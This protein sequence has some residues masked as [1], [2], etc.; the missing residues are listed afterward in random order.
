MGNVQDSES[1]S[2]QNGNSRPP[3]RPPK[4]APLPPT[5]SVY[6][7]IANN[8]DHD[9]EILNPDFNNRPSRP[10]PVRPAPLTPGQST[11]TLLSAQGGLD[12]V[13]FIINPRFMNMANPDKVIFIVHHLQNCLL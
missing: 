13:P 10:A 9:Y 7:T 11:H 8:G 4:P 12:G 2:G 3:E 5:S 6:P 1:E